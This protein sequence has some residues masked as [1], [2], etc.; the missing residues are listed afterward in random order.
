[1]WSSSPWIISAG[2]E[3][4]RYIASL[5][6]KPGGMVRANTVWASTSPVVPEAHSI[7]SSICLVECG[8]EKMLE[9]KKAAKSG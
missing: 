8:S 6:S 4:L 9:T 3:M 7:P 1:M 2:Q 5:T